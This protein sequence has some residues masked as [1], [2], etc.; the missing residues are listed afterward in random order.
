MSEQR[1]ESVERALSLLDC[2][3][4]ETPELTL[5]QL[6]ERS[7]YYRS[8]IL[9]LAGS[10]TRFGYLV[11]EDNGVFRLGPTL[12]RLGVQYERSFKLEGVVRPVLKSLSEASG[13]TAVFYI[14]EGSDRVCLYRHSASRSIRHHVD[15]GAR[16]PLDQGAGGRMLLAMTETE[17]KNSALLAAGVSVSIGER[18]PE[19]FAIAAPVYSAHARPAGVL[20]VV[21]PV[22]RTSEEVISELSD[23]VMQQAHNLSTQL[24]ASIEAGH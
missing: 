15:E 1:V 21:G 10:L 9:R 14:R 17:Q 13:E 3:D 5:G 2:F 23:V 24:G 16:L 11:R 12:L 22:S 18:D 20:A 4:P 19:S 8:T 7:G 6:A